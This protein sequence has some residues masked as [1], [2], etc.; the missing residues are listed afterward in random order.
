MVDPFIQW[1]AFYSDADVKLEYPSETLVRMMKGSYIPEFDRDYKGKKAIDIG[2]GHGNNLLFLAQLG[3]EIFGVEVHKDIC[4]LTTDRLS[5]LEIK[6]NLQCGRN[7]AIP[8]PDNTFDY[9]VSWDVIHYEVDDE[10]IRE[11]IEEYHRVLKPGGRFFLSTVA[12]NNAILSGADI[13][14]CHR[15]KITREDDFRKG[16]IFF[17]FDS[18]AYVEFFFSERFSTVRTGRVSSDIFQRTVDCFIATGVKA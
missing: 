12:P 13:I 2:F 10:H 11:A 6:A 4:K 16:E 15:Y 3:L 5:R 8:F 14:G 1:K 18:P 17:C 7:R 9:L